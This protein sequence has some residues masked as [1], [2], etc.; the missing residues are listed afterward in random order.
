[1]YKKLKVW[2]LA[3]DLVLEIYQIA[4]QFPKTEEYNLKCQLKRAIVS[5]PLNIAEGKTRILLRILAIF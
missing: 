3:M 2:H 4:E 1:M 5:V